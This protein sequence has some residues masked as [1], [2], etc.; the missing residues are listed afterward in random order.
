M[1]NTKQERK[2]LWY[3]HC[4]SFQLMSGWTALV[5]DPCHLK[6]HEKNRWKIYVPIVTKLRSWWDNPRNL[7]SD[8]NMVW[9][10]LSITINLP[11]SESRAD[12]HPRQQDM[13]FIRVFSKILS[14]ISVIGWSTGCTSSYVQIRLADYH[15]LKK[16]KNKQNKNKTPNT[17]I[18]RNFPSVVTT[19]L[20]WPYESYKQEKKAL[21]KNKNTNE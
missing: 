9:T 21:Y 15:F 6:A 18:Q 19:I 17:K 13:M 8:Q 2:A 16:K 1:I 14:W 11:F 5:S 4:L 20:M 10:Q 7:S 3:Y 12:E